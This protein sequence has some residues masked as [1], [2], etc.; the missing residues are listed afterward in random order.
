MDFSKIDKKV[1]TWLLIALI[2]II[3]I[4]VA[5]YWYL[6]TTTEVQNSAG[7]ASTENQSED[8]SQS[9]PDVQI[10]GVNAEGVQQ[11]GL[12]ICVDEC[13]NGVCQPIDENCNT[14]L[15]CICPETAQSCPDDCK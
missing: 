1:L 8:N 7:G 13:G 6:G 2:G 3:V 14:N 10:E 11:G 4:G 12:I 5:A 9:A 15:N